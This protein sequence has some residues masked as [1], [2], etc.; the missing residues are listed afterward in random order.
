MVIEGVKEITE[1]RISE[2]QG[3]FRKGWEC[4]NQIYLLR[5]VVL[6]NANKREQSL[7]CFHGF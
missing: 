2:E 5:M 7:C 4:M 3:G 6:K 1:S